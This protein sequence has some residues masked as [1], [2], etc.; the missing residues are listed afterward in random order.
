MN[1]N[2]DKKEQSEDNTQQKWVRRHSKEIAITV[3]SFVSTVV[4]GGLIIPYAFQQIENSQKELEIK[5]NLIKGMAE[6]V[7]D[8]VG[9]V[10]VL[11]QDFAG[12]Y[13]RNMLS[14]PGNITMTNE[15]LE[16]IQEARL[17]E[18]Q[19]RSYFPERNFSIAKEWNSVAA[20]A[21]NFVSLYSVHDP[22]NRTKII[23]DIYRF[24][25]NSTVIDLLTNKIELDPER[26]KY[27]TSYFERLFG[28]NLTAIEDLSNR[29]GD[30]N[31]YKETYFKI[32][33]LIKERFDN[34]SKTILDSRIPQYR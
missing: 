2:N 7:M 23:G 28:E 8:P 15:R 1:V 10:Q 19:L 16:L 18:P 3:I 34:L 21:Y 14:E 29:N 31:K 26:Q 5:V 20:I 11:E 22:V 32:Q 25:V 30:R 13:P 17:I 24:F 27:Q 33:E 4:I 6:A 9:K 12:Y